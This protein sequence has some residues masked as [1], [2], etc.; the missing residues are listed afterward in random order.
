MIAAALPRFT[1]L[2]CRSADKRIFFAIQCNMTALSETTLHS[3]IAL[4]VVAATHRS[5]QLQGSM[6]PVQIPA[7]CA[8]AWRAHE[9]S[10][11]KPD[12]SIEPISIGKT[13]RLSLAA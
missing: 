5:S 11:A 2:A 13:Y 4:Q 1:Y 7:A 6:D 3:E 12:P 9:P 10:F 8:L